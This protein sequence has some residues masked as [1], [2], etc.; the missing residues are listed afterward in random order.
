[1]SLKIHSVEVISCPRLQ[2]SWKPDAK[3]A[4]PA[5]IRHLRRLVPPRHRW[6]LRQ[7]RRGALPAQG[8]GRKTLQD[9]LRVLAKDPCLGLVIT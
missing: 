7:R 9:P 1:M 4:F 2:N 6:S 5:G 3:A 8:H